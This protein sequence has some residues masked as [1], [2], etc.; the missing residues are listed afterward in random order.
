MADVLIMQSVPNP[1]TSPHDPP[2]RQ[3]LADLQHGHEEHQAAALHVTEV[4]DR[5][6]LRSVGDFYRIIAIA[7]GGIACLPE[8]VFGMLCPK[9][10]DIAAYRM[11]E[12]S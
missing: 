1:L 6:L 5:H 8:I 9:A 3:D 12:F 10:V 11:S 2:P 4:T 7:I